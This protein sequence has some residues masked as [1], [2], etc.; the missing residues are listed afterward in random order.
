MNLD[1]TLNPHFSNV[2]V[3]NV[4]TNLTRFEI[5]LPE[6]RQFFIDNN[7]LFGTFGNERDSNPFF[8]R[9][10]GLAKNKDDETIENRIIGGMRLS[11][12]LSEDWRL[13]LLSIQTDEDLENEIASNNNTM[14]SLQK[15]YS[16][17]LILAYF[18]L[19]EKLSR[20]MTSLALKKSTTGFLVL[21]IT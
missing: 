10:I 7:D 11:G 8:S 4:V 18:S 6:R 1:L 17:D 13:G 2:E 5:S 21:T 12:K 16:Q 20:I 14:F 9:R 19:T 3:D 15:N